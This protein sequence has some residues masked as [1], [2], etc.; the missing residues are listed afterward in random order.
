MCSVKVRQ[1]L[2]EATTASSEKSTATNILS[3]VDSSK[4]LVKTFISLIR[5]FPTSSTHNVFDV[6]CVNVSLFQQ[7]SQVDVLTAEW[8]ERFL[9]AILKGLNIVYK[10]LEN[11]TA[12]CS[13]LKAV[14]KMARE[15]QILQKP[16][17]VENKS[18]NRAELDEMAIETAKK[19]FQPV[20]LIQFY[21]SCANFVGFCRWS[22]ALSSKSLLKHPFLLFKC[23]MFPL[24]R[25]FVSSESASLSL[26][27]P[28]ISRLTS[29]IEHS[30]T[31][32]TASST[33]LTIIK[34]LSVI[35]Q[36]IFHSSI[37][38][39]EISMECHDEIIQ[40]SLQ[41]A[42]ETLYRSLLFPLIGILC[43]NE[44]YSN[45]CR[46]LITSIA[47]GRPCSYPTIISKALASDKSAAFCVKWILSNTL[48]SIDSQFVDHRLVLSLENTAHK[49]N[50]QIFC[51]KMLRLIPEIEHEATTSLFNLFFNE[52]PQVKIAA[53]KALALLNLNSV[54]I[55]TQIGIRNHDDNCFKN[56][57]LHE[58]GDERFPFTKIL[59]FVNETNT[60]KRLSFVNG[61]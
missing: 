29:I 26:C 1:I 12:V 3:E 5:S 43:T 46:D 61:F 33:E 36:S 49:V 27:T 37:E 51:I 42:S 39:N 31:V 20:F 54:E 22:S 17:L 6:F 7:E 44:R 23:I 15:S 4:L 40:L 28:E 45:L 10:R 14:G 30:L 9:N 8:I 38:D 11:K 13:P 35:I 32:N 55:S 47:N 52:N 21:S 41:N 34:H 16:V 57:K 56:V 24:L 59:T 19:P 58:I 53:C 18:R 48:S 50:L 2:L 25:Q 60:L